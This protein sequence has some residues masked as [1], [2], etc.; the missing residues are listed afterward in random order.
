MS[1]YE[2]G[3]SYEEI[4]ERTLAKVSTDVD[5]REGSVIWNAMAPTNEEIANIFVLLDAIYENGFA[6]TAE[7]DYLILRCKERGI[8]PEPATYAVLKGEFNMEIPIGNRFNLGDL[9]YVVTAFINSSD[10]RYYYQLKCETEGTEGNVQFGELSAIDFVDTNM[11]G[12]IV[13][14]LIPAEDEEDTENLRRRYLDSFN[15]TPF[16]GNQDDYKNEVSKLDGVGGVKIIPVWNGGGTVK[17]IIINS[18]YDKASSTLVSTVQNAIDPS[19]QG[20]GA[21]LAPIG[22]TVTVESCKERNITINFKCTFEDGYSWNTVQSEVETALEEYLLELRKN[23]ANSSASIVRISQIENRTLNID[24]IIDVQG[25][26]INNSSE[27]L[28]L[29]FE[30]IPILGGVSN[31]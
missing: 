23:W 3:N 29:K 21:G 22:H 14:L 26:T 8:T 1:K 13:E 2:D 31:A 7:R 9:N 12:S 10:N 27:N 6:D 11:E 15:T 16:G 5:K 19:P 17:L 28:T 25:T 18:N 4:M 30:E 20:T 24:G